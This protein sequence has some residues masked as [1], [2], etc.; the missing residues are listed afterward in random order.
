MENAD[1]C[2]EPPAATSDFRPELLLEELAECVLLCDEHF[3]LLWANRS[4]I[5]LWGY[6]RDH[7]IGASLETMLARVGREFL[8]TWLR[9]KD[10][11]QTELRAVNRGGI[12]FELDASVRCVHTLA[13]ERVLISGKNFSA[14]KRTWQRLQGEELTYRQIFENAVEGIFQTSPDGCYLAANKSLARI[15]GYSSPEQLMTTL[16]DIKS[17][18][19]VDPNRRFEF[20]QGIAKTGVISDFESEIY[21]KDGSIIWISENARMV[22]SPSGKFLFYE[23]NVQDITQRKK[24]ERELTQAK[25]AAEA[26]NRAKSEFLATMSHELRTPLNGIIGMTALLRDTPVAGSQAEFIDTIQK[27]GESLLT[28]VNDLLDFSKVESGKFTPEVREFDLDREIDFCVDLLGKQAR[29]KGLDLRCFVHPNVPEH[30]AGDANRV[31]QVLLNLLG[32]AIKFTSKGEVALEV[33]ADSNITDHGV[34]RFEIRDTGIG[35]PAE[36]TD[37]LFKPF[38]QADASHARRFGGAGLGLAISKRIVEALGGVIGFESVLGAGS[39]FW[40]AV[41]FSRCLALKRPEPAE[42]IKRTLLVTSNPEG[43]PDLRRYLDSLGMSVEAV[44]SP[45]KALS[46][47]ISP[48]GDAPELIFIEDALPDIR[49]I[50]FARCVKLQ[51]P[52]LPRMILLAPGPDLLPPA[53]LTAAGIAV[54]LPGPLKRRSLISAIRPQN[55]TPIVVAPARIQKERELKTNAAILLAEDNSVNRTVALKHLAKLGFEA[56]HV[57]NGLEVLEKIKTRRYDLILMDCQMPEMDGFQA[58]QEIRRL[59]SAQGTAP[60]HIVALTANA[61]AGDRDRCLAAGMNDY[62]SK[63]FKSDDLAR[64][65]ADNL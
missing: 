32:N 65:L 11:V 22:R 45:T 31:K 20:I 40:F 4:A 25:L 64:V 39:R 55:A 10:P 61:M 56:D 62:L 43:S 63:P 33:T 6:D 7:F 1:L 52:Q 15:Y 38:T 18:L 2:F 51:T 37:K 57:W 30:V 26:A 54:S 13:G 12:T 35:I 9:T 17:Q 3:N 36:I 46:L 44:A 34:L 48:G 42:L 59:E 19:Y 41:P 24:T 21:R 27:S 16:N 58:T 28:L 53:D 14:R 23:G 50:D 8:Q 5:A 60:V 29:A 47:A 49:G